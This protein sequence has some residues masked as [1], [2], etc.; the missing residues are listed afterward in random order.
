MASAQRDQRRRGAS[1][2][3]GGWDG[4][5]SATQPDV[6][7]CHQVDRRDPRL[8]EDPQ[9]VGNTRSRRPQAVADPPE[10]RCDAG[11]EELAIV[12]LVAAD[13]AEHAALLMLPDT[14]SWI[15]GSSL[16][17]TLGLLPWLLRAV[18]VFVDV[19]VTLGLVIALTH[20]EPPPPPC[21]RAP[22]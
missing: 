5:P 21:I 3:E 14:W 9:P 20:L 13:T 17:P 18:V 6:A 8:S 16:P 2:D 1:D 12:L 7:R 22:A 19:L 11:L 10:A 15:F 4:T